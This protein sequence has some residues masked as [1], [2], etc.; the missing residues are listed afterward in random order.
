MG[1]NDAVFCVCSPNRLIILKWCYT[2]WV[3]A[4]WLH[5]QS[6]VGVAFMHPLKYI[7]GSE[8]KT[9]HAAKK[10]QHN[11]MLNSLACTCI[12]EFSQLQINI[13]GIN[14]FLFHKSLSEK[15]KYRGIVKIT[16]FWLFSMLYYAWEAPYI[17]KLLYGEF[18]T[19]V[20]LN[21]QTPSGVIYPVKD[22]LSILTGWF[23]KLCRIGTIQSHIIT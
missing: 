13:L 12:Y 2:H 14:N 11:S 8:A 7:Y 22:L 15:V 5:L 6:V 9:K 20:V 16:D 18:T 19:L 21:T 17:V 4:A 10:R 1:L 23:W 3:T